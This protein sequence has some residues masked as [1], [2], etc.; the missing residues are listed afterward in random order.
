MDEEAARWHGRGGSE[1]AQTRRWRDGMDEE[2]VRWH[3]QGGRVCAMWVPGGG[4]VARMKGKAVWN[5]DSGEVAQMKGKATWNEDG[6]VVAW[7][8]DALGG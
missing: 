4:G 3:G 2:A 5:E 8:G 6:G 7:E 1:V